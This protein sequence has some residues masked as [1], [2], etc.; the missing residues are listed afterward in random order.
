[1]LKINLGCG[2][3]PIQGWENLDILDHPGIIKH[4]LTK[5]LPY[6]DSSID[7]I[8]SEHFFEHLDEVDGFRLLQS[9][10]KTLK[11]SGVLRIS[12]PSLDEILKI[13]N[14]WDTSYQYFH[15]HIKQFSNP[16]QFINWAFFGESSTLEKNKFLN[17]AISTNDGHKFLYSKQDLIN[18]LNIIGYKKID[19]VEK[20]I[21]TNENL[22]NLESRIQICDLTMEAVK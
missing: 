20:N 8:Y 11:P 3:T 15:P 7:L 10:Y 1:M 18:K 16:N 4:D 21:S 6:E 9:C 13:Y 2:F 14:T 5:P 22:K 12:M 19:F 17:G